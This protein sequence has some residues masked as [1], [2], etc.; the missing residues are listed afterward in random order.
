MTERKALAQIGAHLYVRADLVFM[1]SKGAVKTEVRM[2]N[3]DI[4]NTS[5]PVSDV[6]E[7][8]NKALADDE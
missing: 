6:A 3:G 4:W 7:S 2:S 1:V 8:I 5:W